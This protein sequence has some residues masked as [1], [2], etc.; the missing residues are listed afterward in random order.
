MTIDELIT[1][2]EEAREDLG[3]HARSGSPA[4]PATPYAR[5]SS[6]SPSRTAPTRPNSTAP[7]RRPPARA[8][9]AR[10]SGWPPATSWTA[11]TPTHPSGPGS[12]PTSPDCGTAVSTPAVTWPPA[13]APSP[14]PPPGRP[15]AR[16]P[17]PRPLS[18]HRTRLNR[19]TNGEGVRIQPADSSHRR[20]GVRGIQPTLT[21]SGLQRS[22]AP[23]RAV[24]LP[25]PPATVLGRPGAEHSNRRP[26]HERFPS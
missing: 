4:S 20:Q 19:Q 18:H 15:P 3:G 17:R 22:R 6:T 11:R 25:G 2:A 26:A 9:T 10:S 12:A 14:G 1:L 13:S 24:C 16:R 5:P 23:V 7:T 8:T 21:A